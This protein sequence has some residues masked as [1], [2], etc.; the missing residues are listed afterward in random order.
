MKNLIKNGVLLVILLSLFTYFVFALTS[1]SVVSPTISQNVSGNLL[2]N[3]TTDL[4]AVNTTFYW[5]DASSGLLTYNITLVNDTVDDTVFNTTID[6]SLVI[7]DGIYNVTV[8]AT[9]LTGSTVSNT[10]ITG[11]TVDNTAPTVTLVTTSTNTTDTTPAIIFN[12][13]DALFATASCVLY[14]NNTAYNTSIVNNATDTTLIVNTTLSDGSYLVNVNCTDGSS[15]EGTSS[16]ITI[17]V[18]TGIPAVT[19][20]NTP[21]S[22]SYNDEDFI[23]NVTVT[24]T[25]STVQYMLENGSNSSQ[26]IVNYTTMSNPSG[27]FWNATIDVSAIADWNYTIRINATDASGNSN[28]TETLV[29]NIDDTAPSVSSFSCSNVNK[30]ASQS[31]SCSAT[32]NSQS[33]GGSVSTSISSASTSTTGTK[34]V[35]CT[36][37][38]SAGNTATSDTTY[39]VS[40]SSGSGSTGSAGGISTSMQGEYE[41]KIWTSINEGETATVEVENEEIGVTEI[42]FVADK[43]M[44]GAWIKVG[45]IESVP[46][47]VKSFTN[48][49]YKLVKITKGSTV[50]EDSIKDITIDFKV[51]KSW[52]TDNGIG[53]GDVALFRY[54]G[55]E[56]VELSTLVNFEDNNYIYY[57]AETP[58]FSYFT[59]GQK[60]QEVVLEVEEVVTDE[61]VVALE[62]EEVITDEVEEISEKGNLVWLWVLVVLA[63]IGFSVWWFVLRDKPRRKKRK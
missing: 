37:T 12:Y 41:K 5:Y 38:D 8:N 7:T 26:V 33:F 25:P 49:I 11:V 19:T 24:G 6:T 14:F 53:E 51:D 1:V 50:N 58:G 48:K 45:Q 56:W 36:A 30:G 55:D 62:A 16:S 18:D 61:E 63:I 23:L 21:T 57:T 35:T 42:N 46:S 40:S 59:I 43:T 22:A 13:T 20:F 29:I 39:T 60:D 34:T 15:N 54:V 31:C 9:N 10:T 3:S 2:L 4:G 27:N 47:T 28:T 44:W 17:N 32:D 52:L